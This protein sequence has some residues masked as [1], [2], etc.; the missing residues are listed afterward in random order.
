MTKYNKVGKGAAFIREKT[1][2]KQ[3][4]F[5]GTVTVMDK[6]FMVSLWKSR[7]KKGDPYLSIQFSERIEDDADTSGPW[8]SEK[9][10]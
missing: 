9:K 7:T 6:E 4:D 8:D 2:E 1:N 10:A 5:G 3:P